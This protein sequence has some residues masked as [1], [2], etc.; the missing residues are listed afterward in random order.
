MLL[1]TVV[2]L[3]TPH[4][5]CHQQQRPQRRGCRQRTGQQS[6]VCVCVWSGQRTG[7]TG[8]QQL[9]REDV[10]TNG[11][12]LSFKHQQRRQQCCNV[13]THTHTHSCSFLLLCACT[14]CLPACAAAVADLE[15]QAATQE[16]RDA[17][18]AP[19]GLPSGGHVPA[20]MGPAVLMGAPIRPPGYNPPAGEYPGAVLE[21]GWDEALFEVCAC[22]CCWCQ[23]TRLRMNAATVARV[24]FSGA[25][26]CFLVLPR[27][28]L[29]RHHP[30]LPYLALSR[31][32][33]P[34]PASGA[35]CHGGW[36]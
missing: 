5:L 10:H 2:H 25:V 11:P 23:H 22:E 6:Q 16:A 24:V 15:A 17:A 9:V 3:T 18:L 35:A 32:P 34:T 33:P 26:V 27:P 36:C 7:T 28:M 21:E 30:A 31:L 8:F 13:L 29:H 20:L 4:P 1:Q 14:A 19:P 12:R